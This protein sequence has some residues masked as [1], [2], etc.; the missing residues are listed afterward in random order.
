LH[1]RNFGFGP[2]QSSYVKQRMREFAAAVEQTAAR[3]A[4]PSPTR[5]G[6]RAVLVNGVP[7]SDEQVGHLESTYRTRMQDG[8]YWYD[9]HCGAWGMQGG[10]TLGFTQ[11]G[12][13]LGGPL[14]SDASSGDTG[15]FINGRQL[16]RLDVQSL[17]QLGPVWPGRYWLDA[18]GNIGFEGGVMIGNLWQLAQQRQAGNSRSGGPWSVYA[19]GGVVAGDGQGGLFAQFGDQTWSNW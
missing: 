8:A 9:R 12:L 4:R 7:L 17:Q 10:P 13:D 16:H 1:G 6:S 5:R 18:A 14:R 11:P 15:V 19:G 2:L 3:D